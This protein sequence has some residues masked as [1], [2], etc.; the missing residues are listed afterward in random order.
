LWSDNS[1]SQN[2]TITQNGIYSLTI[3]DT[4][5]CIS[6][7]DPVE[8]IVNEFPII[9]A[10]DFS[11]PI[12]S[13]VFTLNNALP[14]GGTY[15]GFGVNNNR[16]NPLQVGLGSHTISYRF[17]N[18]AGCESIETFAITVTDE[19]G[20]VPSL[21]IN[22]DDVI[23][24]ADTIL[25]NGA[26]NGEYDGFIWVVEGN[27]VIQLPGSFNA[28]YFVDRTD[29]YIEVKFYAWNDLDTAMATKTIL[30]VGEFTPSFTWEVNPESPL[31]VMFTS[32]IGNAESYDW[33]FGDGNSGSGFEVEHIYNQ[34]G[35][36]SI[37]LQLSKSGCTSETDWE[38]TLDDGWDIFIPSGIYASS[39]NEE[40]S[41]AKLYGKGL[42]DDGF[43]WKIFNRWGQMM[44]QSNDLQDAMTTG[45]DGTSNGSPLPIG[46][47]NYVVQVRKYDTVFE[48]RSG[49]ITIFR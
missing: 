45:W 11:A 12:E 17:Q 38:I 32:E 49:T 16:F 41:R 27:G 19:P 30:V 29:E 36:Y 37:N 1:T 43:V 31:D 10:E 20:K 15:F 18:S 40:N 13:G 7:S 22:I 35:I 21:T 14:I 44:Y 6:V 3:E 28:K 9:T 47:Y 24:Q 42:N 4:R 8:L 33:D 25:L 34:S 5:G 39:T 26:I 48:T 46:E 23:C 2:L